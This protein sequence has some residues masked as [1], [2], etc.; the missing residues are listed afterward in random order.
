VWFHDVLEADG[1]P[2]RQSE[3]DYIRKVTG[4]K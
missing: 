3:V 2:F 1:R 4:A